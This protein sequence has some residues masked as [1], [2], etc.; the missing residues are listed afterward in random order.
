[1]K[2]SVFWNITP[3]RLLKAR[4]YSVGICRLYFQGQRIILARNQHEARSKTFVAQ[5]SV[6]IPEGRNLQ[7]LSCETLKFNKNG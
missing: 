3:Y 6:Y 2:C 7:I 1:M 4:R 5:D